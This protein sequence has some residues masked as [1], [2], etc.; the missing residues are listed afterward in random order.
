MSKSFLNALKRSMLLEAAS[1]KD[2]LIKVIEEAQKEYTKLEKAL[3]DVT[4][5]TK[6]LPGLFSSKIYKGRVHNLDTPNEYPV[7]VA[8]ED[9]KDMNELSNAI[10][11]GRQSLSRAKQCLEKYT[12]S[13]KITRA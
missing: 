10:R 13:S 5:L 11:E 2:E 6:K 4:N 3:S 8:I 7:W 12:P 9:V 1:N